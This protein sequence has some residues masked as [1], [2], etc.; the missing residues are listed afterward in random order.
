MAIHD[1]DRHTRQ[2]ISELLTSNRLLGLKLQQQYYI[3]AVVNAVHLQWLDKI[4]KLPEYTGAGGIGVHLQPVQEDNPTS[5]LPNEESSAPFEGNSLDLSTGNIDQLYVHEPGDGNLI[6]M[7]AAW[8]VGSLSSCAAQN[9]CLNGDVA[10]LV[11]AFCQEF[12]F[13]HLQQFMS[14]CNIEQIAPPSLCL[15][16]EHINIHSP[17]Y[18]PYPTSPVS[19]HITCNA[20][21]APVSG[22]TAKSALIQEAAVL[23][24][25]PKKMSTVAPFATG[26]AIRQRCPAE[27]FLLVT[28]STLSSDF[29]AATQ[30][31]KPILSIGPNSD[32][33][34]DRFNFRDELIPSLCKLMETTR[35]THWEV[36]LREAP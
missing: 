31:I 29:T 11:Q 13:P 19:S 10:V 6:T 21:Q 14:C 25:T 8:T 36:K 9:D 28:D 30:H 22:V 32:V 35:D 3:R 24:I 5:G 4:E 16:A 27:A 1:E 12:A 26:H 20:V 2:V 7:Q 15:P 17:P 18:L 23:N 33:I 34:L